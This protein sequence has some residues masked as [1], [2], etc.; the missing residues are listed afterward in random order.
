MALHYDI[1]IDGEVHA[2]QYLKSLGYIICHNRWRSGHLE[3]DIVAKTNDELI[4][5]E[6]K[7]RS[8]DYQTPED[9]VDMKKIRRLVTAAN[10]YIK[11]YDLSLSPRFDIIFITIEDG[12]S[13]LEHIQDAFYPPLG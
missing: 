11:Q 9:V 10:N 4:F 13:H 1:G 8:N 3:I 7:T 5:V 2:T 6:V 12:K